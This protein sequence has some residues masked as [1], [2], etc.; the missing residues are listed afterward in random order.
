MGALAKLRAF[1]DR[2][3]SDRIGE[4]RLD[5]L[6]C[7]RVSGRLRVGRGVRA[8]LVDS[9]AKARSDDAFVA[10]GLIQ[11]YAKRGR[12]EEAW[13]SFRGAGVKDAVVWSSMITASAR[14]GDFGAALL[15]VKEMLLDGVLPDVIA[16]TAAL[17]A[18]TRPEALSQGKLLHAWILDCG[19]EADL[20]V[21]TALVT[22]YG[23]CGSLERSKDVFDRSSCRRNFVLWTSMI[24][25]Y[26]Q[27]SRFAQALGMFRQM[28]LEG[29]KPNKVT[30]ISIAGGIV[31]MNQGKLIY[32]L[33]RECTLALHDIVVRTAL[34]GM[35]SRCGDIRSCEMLFQTTVC[36][37]GTLSS[38]NVM[39]GVYSEHEK[40]QH[41]A[42]HLFRR[43]LLQACVDAHASSMALELFRRMQLQGVKHNKVTLV[44]VLSACAKCHNI[45]YECSS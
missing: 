25:V 35:F 31:D 17:A 4:P 15:L 12:M 33:A 42:F 5:S 29:V 19:C 9:P 22:M 18:C 38:W 13:E 45:S 6:C 21:V 23:K 24:G 2:I 7:A 44:S 34:I 16:L 30:F 43:M 10:A 37:E 1:A 39:L 36:H 27:H 28:Q 8:V 40:Q 41:K 14:N 20:F 3:E 11:M 26:V 32:E